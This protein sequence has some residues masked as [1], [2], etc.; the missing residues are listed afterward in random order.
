MANLWQKSLK[1]RKKAQLGG[2]E[3]F[4]NLLLS[5]QFLM[6]CPL[7]TKIFLK[8]DV[9]SRLSGAGFEPHF[10]WFFPILVDFGK[11]FSHRFSHSFPP[12][13]IKLSPNSYP[14]QSHNIIHFRIIQRPALLDSRPL[15]NAFPAT[16]SDCMLIFPKF[17]E[18]YEK[19]VYDSLT[20]RLP[21]LIIPIL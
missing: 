15:L 17:R 7:N 1:T 19:T 4:S 21:I 20:E 2:A 6:V 8:L 11:F 3:P 9:K 10:F 16:G 13:I 12:S 14:N 5:F 18:L